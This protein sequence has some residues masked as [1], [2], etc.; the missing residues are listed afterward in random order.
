M[1]ARQKLGCGLR[2][3]APGQARG[4][5]S[6]DFGGP[7][8]ACIKQAPALR[9]RAAFGTFSHEHGA[10]GAVPR[11]AHIESPRSHT[12]NAMRENRQRTLGGG[13]LPGRQRGDEPGTQQ[14]P[15]G[16]FLAQAI[17]THEGLTPGCDTQDEPVATDLH[18]GRH[19]AVDADH[20][21]TARRIGAP[22]EPDGIS[23]REGHRI[24]LSS[25]RDGVDLQDVAANLGSC[26]KARADCGI[27]EPRIAVRWHQNERGLS[28][29]GRPA[30][31][32]QPCRRLSHVPGRAGDQP[33]PILI[34]EGIENGR[35]I[36]RPGERGEFP[37][38]DRALA[39]RTS[40]A[41]K[42]PQRLFQERDYTACLNG[43]ALRRV[44]DRHER[45][46]RRRADLQKREQ[47][48]N[49]QQR[50]LIDH[51]N[52]GG[53]DLKGGGPDAGEQ[54]CES[55]GMVGSNPRILKG[56]S[57]SPSGCRSHDG[58]LL[59]LPTAN[60]A[61]EEGALA[62]ACNAGGGLELGAAKGARHDKLRLPMSGLKNEPASRIPTSTASVVRAKV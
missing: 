45:A 56:G 48:P 19:G 26:L 62:T 18:H 33:R 57:L 55:I 53:A 9:D 60:Q 34:S 47:V 46:S 16:R 52:R 49:R 59:G 31:D 51:Q 38:A 2:I 54:C 14:Q 23:D 6:P 44:P 24:L 50:D 7:D 17:P 58:A 3:L 28:L 22:V 40:H 41:G 10:P 25:Q 42:F 1:G 43:S 12:G 27:D 15:A 61:A 11:H 21:S 5:V 29:A 36:A 35:G 4:D 8:G 37:L 13:S 32:P 39:D 30:F 20:T